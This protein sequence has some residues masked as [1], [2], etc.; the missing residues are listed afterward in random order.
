MAASVVKSKWLVAHG[1]EWAVLP[2]HTLHR[3]GAGTSPL[4]LS[5]S[6][7]DFDLTGL[8]RSLFGKE[9]SSSP[10]LHFSFS[11]SFYRNHPTSGQSS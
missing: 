3:E 1:V 4:W 11:S 6:A 7:F 2:T 5:L 9:L 10:T 8:V